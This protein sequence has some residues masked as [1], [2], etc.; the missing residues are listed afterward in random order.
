MIDDTRIENMTDAVAFD[1]MI[2][3]TGAKDFLKR[4][5]SELTV[6]SK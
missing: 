1:N 4:N 6:N 2:R 3:L 5:A